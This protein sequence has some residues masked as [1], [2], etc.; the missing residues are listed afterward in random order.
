MRR[1][2]LWSILVVLWMLPSFP[3][4]ASINSGTLSFNSTFTG[5]VVDDATSLPIP[6]GVALVGVYYSTNLSAVPHAELAEDEFSLAAVTHVS[7]S[8][9]PLFFG[10]YNGG[11]ISLPGTNPGQTVLVQL[12]AWPVPYASYGEALLAGAMVLSASN[13]VPL[14]LGGGI[15]PPRPLS[16][17][18]LTLLRV[19]FLVEPPGNIPPFALGASYNVET[20]SSLTGQLQGIDRE[21]SPLQYQ[22]V[23]WPELGQL[24]VESDGA[25]TYQTLPDRLGV[26]QFTF[27]ANDGVY[28]SLLATVSITINPV[29]TYLRTVVFENSSN[30]PVYDGR[31]G[32]LVSNGVAKAGL[33]MSFDLAGEAA[34]GSP[35]DPFEIV[36]VSPI[37]PNELSRDQGIFQS[38]PIV[39]EGSLS[40]QQVWLQVRAWTGA[41]ADYESA[42]EDPDSLVAVSRVLGPVMLGGEELRPFTIGLQQSFKPMTLLYHT[43]NH[44][45]KA[46]FASFN[47]YAPTVRERLSG[48]DPDGDSLTFLLTQAPRFGTVELQPDGSFMY[49]TSEPM[50]I[51]DSFKFAVFDGALESEPAIVLINNRQLPN[52]GYPVS[53]V[54]NRDFPILD[55]TTGFPYEPGV[56]VAGLYFTTNISAQPDP[57]VPMDALSLV[58]VAPVS[59]V[60]NPVFFG[61]F[62]ASGVRLPGASVGQSAL[63]QTRIWSTTYSTYA[64]AVENGD[65]RIQ[66]SN[67]I[68]PI[69]LYGGAAPTYSVG[70]AITGYAAVPP[71][72]QAPDPV[73]IVSP[74]INLFPQALEQVVIASNNLEALVHL[75]GSLSSDPD[76]DALSWAWYEGT[77]PDPAAFGPQVSLQLPLGLHEIVML[78]DDG[79]DGAEAS[80]W[81]DVISRSEALDAVLEE[82]S[83]FDSPGTQSIRASLKA[84]RASF[85]RFHF[86]A[87]RNQLRAL[88]KKLK[89]QSNKLSPATVE[90]LSLLVKSIL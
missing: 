90:R 6:P 27:R 89:S 17:S 46:S 5:M 32:L 8:P 40:V 55:P 72:N 19:H 58:V 71:P 18:G 29:Q 68:G 85:E 59:P 86:K 39:I 44:A 54:G 38:E 83:A 21:G 20:G 28:D 30:N 31:T 42:L 78:V 63:L 77:G 23:D 67:V 47:S 3:A 57:T 4:M 11:Y 36:T 66:V 65:E 26:D 37:S 9:N 35:E 60:D 15:I 45:P 56:V 81:V 69:Q 7:P 16:T 82:F 14:S 41:S 24:M 80:V 10:L 50:D 25:F 43:G 70:I 73:I 61:W 33:Y 79:S 62:V 34:P 52:Q 76:G 12:R 13:V 64:E 22:V 88:V 75:D 51:L 48:R 87:G 74:T 53:F 1:S 49:Q 2:W 84:A